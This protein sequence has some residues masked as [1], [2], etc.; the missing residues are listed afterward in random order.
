MNTLQSN[1]IVCYPNPVKTD[2]VIQ[3]NSLLEGKTYRLYNIDGRLIK[4]GTL[5]TNYTFVQSNDL[6][7]GMY[8][9]KIEGVE[10]NPIKVIKQ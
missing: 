4:K 3:T 9:I 2:F 8:L 7:S 5:N 6:S 1:Q 10:S